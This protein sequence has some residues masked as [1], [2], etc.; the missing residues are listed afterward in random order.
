MI[1]RY[2]E[3][4]KNKRNNRIFNTVIKISHSKKGVVMLKNYSSQ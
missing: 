2:I 1:K 3:T 4:Y